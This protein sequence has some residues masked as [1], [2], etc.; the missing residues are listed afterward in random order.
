MAKQRR[1]HTAEE[2]VSI[3][4]RHLLVQVPSPSCATNGASS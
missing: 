2:E 3:L 4:L 1:R